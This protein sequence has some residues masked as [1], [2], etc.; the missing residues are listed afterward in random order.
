[1]PK[2]IRVIYFSC[3]HPPSAQCP[4]QDMWTFIYTTDIYQ[5]HQLSTDSFDTVGA[6]GV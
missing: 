5:Y 4:K 2:I 6:A 1:M 3:I